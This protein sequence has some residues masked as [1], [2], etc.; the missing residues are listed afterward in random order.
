MR[1]TPPPLVIL[2]DG[3]LV[4]LLF[5]PVC[6]AAVIG[7]DALR[8]HLDWHWAQERAGGGSGSHSS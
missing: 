2:A 8:E 3:R 1:D 6:Y 5:C 7:E 4:T